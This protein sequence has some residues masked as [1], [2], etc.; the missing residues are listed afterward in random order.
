[1]HMVIMDH[2]NVVNLIL[3]ILGFSYLLIIPV[4]PFIFFVIYLCQKVKVDQPVEESVQDTP[5]ELD[6]FED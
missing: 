1:M 6:E 2:I 3:I 4:A 5:I